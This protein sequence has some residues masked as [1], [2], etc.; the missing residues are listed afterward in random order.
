MLFLDEIM[1]V[2]EA[3]I[4]SKK[5]DQILVDTGSSIDVLFKSTMEEMRITYLRIEHT[6][7]SL[8]GFGGGRLSPLAWL[9]YPSR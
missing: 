9:S 7:T 4:A 5:F 6:N 8:K 3:T 1:L 2:I